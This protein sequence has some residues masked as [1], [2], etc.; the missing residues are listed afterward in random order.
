LAHRVDGKRSWCTDYFGD[1][2]ELIQKRL[3]ARER[4]QGFGHLL[5]ALP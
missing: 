4:R 3:H 1:C 2:K 5:A